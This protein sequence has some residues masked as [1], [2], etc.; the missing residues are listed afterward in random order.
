MI[1]GARPLRIESVYRIGRWGMG[2]CVW[3]IVYRGET[4]NPDFVVV[5]DILLLN[6]MISK[7]WYMVIEYHLNLG[8]SD[9]IEILIKELS[10]I[11]KSCYRPF[12]ALVIRSKR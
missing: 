7:A 3:R 12:Y 11:W 1:N 10:Q 9:A 2:R 6:Q 8:P 5:G 4:G